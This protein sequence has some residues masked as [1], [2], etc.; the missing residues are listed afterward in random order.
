MAPI[1]LPGVVKLE[2]SEAPEG[3][4]IIPGMLSL[5]TTELPLLARKFLVEADPLTRGVCEKFLAFD[6]G[7]FSEGDYAI[8]G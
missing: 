7:A 5:W 4:C 1:R 6:R 8:V 2:G 3:E